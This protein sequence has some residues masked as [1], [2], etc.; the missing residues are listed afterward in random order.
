MN[1]LCTSENGKQ[2][3]LAGNFIR[4]IRDIRAVRVVFWFCR[5]ESA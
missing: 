4:V 3:L 1:C 5:P 2:K